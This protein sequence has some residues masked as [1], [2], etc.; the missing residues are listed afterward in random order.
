MADSRP[1]RA[2]G[3]LPS[4]ATPGIDP[5]PVRVVLVVGRADDAALAQAGRLGGR[6]V[7]TPFSGLNADLLA[8]T[9]PDAV[10]FPL[11]AA[12]F[13]ALQVIDRLVALRYAGEAC[14]MAPILPNRRMVEA[15][16]RSHGPGL[17]LLLVEQPARS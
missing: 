4:I 5:G 7:L 12:G 6:M 16:L 2:S 13:D 15:E 9:M 11:I 8:R 17:R 14:V 3:L 1:P 10:I